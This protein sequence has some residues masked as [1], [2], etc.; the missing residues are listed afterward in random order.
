MGKTFKRVSIHKSAVRD[1]LPGRVLRACTEQPASVIPTCFKQT[2]VVPV[3]KNAKVTCIN[4]YCPVA[5]TSV[6]RKC[7]KRACHGSH[8]NQTLHS[9]VRT[10]YQ[11]SSM[12]VVVRWFG[13]LALIKETMNSP[14]YQK[15]RI[16]GLVKV[17]S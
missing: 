16:S 10:S 2:T 13:R 6:V 11:W 4:D 8:Q 14:L 17:Q 3:P 7:F 15:R 1:G 12:V 5:L 9:T